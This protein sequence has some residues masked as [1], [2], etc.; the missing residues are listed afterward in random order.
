[1]LQEIK[2]I[3][4]AIL[5]SLAAFAGL[6]VILIAGV[7]VYEEFNEDQRV[8]GLLNIS[9]PPPSMKVITCKTASPLTAD[10][11]TSYVVISQ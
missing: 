5:L 11:I 8:A 4:K 10:I 2:R 9:T 7:L 3:L 1:M 6:L